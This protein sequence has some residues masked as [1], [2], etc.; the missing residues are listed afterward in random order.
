MQHKITYLKDINSKITTDAYLE[1]FVCSNHAVEPERKR[2]AMLICPG[3]GYGHVS[4]REG[5]PVAL[6]YT[7]AGFH[8]FV[9]HYSVAPA[10]YPT[11][12]WEASAA[13]CY[14]REKA[15]EY[16]IDS[17]KII[18]LGFSAGGHLACSLGLLHNEPEVKENLGLKGDE[19][20]PNGMVLCYPVISSFGEKAHKG[21][22]IN[23][24][25]GSEEE[26]KEL[27]EKLSLENRV[28]KNAPPAFIWHTVA[29]AGVPVE[30]SLWLATALQQNGISYEMHL[31][32]Y[33]GHGLSLANELVYEQKPEGVDER[34]TNW[35]ELSVGWVKLL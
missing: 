12:L 8:A 4:P 7:A 22:F 27:F 35:V 34:I 20:R 15:E 24:C 18:V 17:N 33:G 3:G 32:P 21:S 23:L 28:T 26:K 13:M 19:N 30:N 6:Q 9:L 11:Q 10:V 1:E 5:E 16:S 14:L 31:Y 29:D 25:G 2:P